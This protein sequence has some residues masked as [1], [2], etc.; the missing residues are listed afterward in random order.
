MAEALPS[1]EEATGQQRRAIEAPMGPVLVVAGPGAGKTFCLIGRVGYLLGS[2]GLPPR[3]ICAVTFTNKA[4]EEIATRLHRSVGHVAEDVT[5]GTLH[6]LC[7][8]ILREYGERLGLRRGFGVADDAYQ[9]V[10]LARLEI[11]RR[12]RDL[13]LGDFGRHRLQGLHLAPDSERLYQRY[14]AYLRKQNLIDFDDIIALTR[15]LFDRDADVAEAVA[16]RWDY[17]LVDEFQDLNPAQYAV[18]RVLARPHGNFF[19][20]GDDEQSIFSWT[21]ADPAV[22]RR[23]QKDYGIDAPIMLD[24]NRRSARAIFDAARR[25]LGANPRL[26]DKQLT[27]SRE[28][29][30]QV[31]AVRCRDEEAEAAWVVDDLLADRARHGLG[32]GQYAVLYR[33]HGIGRHLESTLVRHGIPC[34]M[35]RG[36]AL[37]DDPVI[38]YV[39][40]SLRVLA[41]PGDDAAIEAFARI[42]LPEDLIE[43]V[44]A[45]AG[46][47]SFLDALRGAAVRRTREDPDRKKMWRF[48]FHVENLQAVRRAQ[49]TF[50]AMVEELL[51]QFGG[52]YRNRLDDRHDELT[53]PADDPAVVALADQLAR[54]SGGVWVEPAGGMDIALRGMLRSAGM[55]VSPAPGGATM[56]LAAAPVT[57][58]KAL[59]LLHSREFREGLE[60]YVTFDLETT[61]RDPATCAII[62]V[63]AARVVRGTVTDRFHS[64]VRA[65]VPISV[66]ASETHGY[67]DGDLAGAP[68]FGEIWPAFRRFVGAST[69]VAHNAH[70]F[71]VPVLRRA[72]AGLPGIEGLVFLDT[73]PLA[74]SLYRE[75]ASLGA[76]AQRFGIPAGRAHHAADDAVTLAAVFQHLGHAKVVRARKTSLTNLLDYLGLALAFQQGKGDAE[77]ELLRGAAQAYTLGRFSD[78]LEVYATERELGGRT[79]APPL[80]WVIDRLGGREKMERIRARKTASQRYPEA[81]ARLTRL[82]DASRGDSVDERLAGFLERVALSSSE[83]VEADPHR[84]NLLTLHST[85]G[86]EFSRVYIL[87]VEDDQLPGTRVLAENRKG[88]IEEHRRL[89]YVG[90]TRAMD[91]LV[92]TRVDVR[93]GRPA[94][95]SRF[96]DE[97]G[98]GAEG[99]TGK[100]KRET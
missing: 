6:A 95:G 13:V 67:T 63:G 64:L 98:I 33:R 20:V 29:P 72:A 34:R 2:G 10:V 56:A 41:A 71:D 8:A 84:V 91:R 12:R 26:F 52:R 5:R 69:L 30:F 74:R 88:D 83:G 76:L 36:R 40:A 65:A 39:V 46:A 75:S 1:G 68:S 61:G 24:E 35:A 43:R 19:A 81:M 89:L 96:L 27:A 15:D 7:L 93:D 31:R 99:E 57:L 4:A 11:P 38:G 54:A 9:R 85:K 14:R 23:F 97:M 79:D 50:E 82:M 37:R 58:F 45:E 18:L 21:G 28:S 62:E 100:G 47:G 90:M 92:L 51:S 70:R 16:R 94:G 48:I 3:R 42:L 44:R 49:P 25:L 55:A 60:E 86:L 73:Y 17:L 77:T 59:Q 22:L 87:G 78:C 53:D 32:W 80:E 66:G